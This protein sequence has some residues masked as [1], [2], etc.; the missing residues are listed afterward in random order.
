MLKRGLERTHKF[1]GKG[2]RTP[3]KKSLSFLSEKLHILMHVTPGFKTCKLSN[4]AWNSSPQ[5]CTPELPLATP[6]SARREAESNTFPVSSY[7][8]LSVSSFRFLHFLSFFNFSI[9][10]KTIQ[11]S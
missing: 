8:Y 7:L 9:Q 6:M 1:S 3:L 10:P 4:F 2:H 11:N 5:G